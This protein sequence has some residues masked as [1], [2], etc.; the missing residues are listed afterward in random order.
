MPEVSRVLPGVT[1]IDDGGGVPVRVV[2]V[3][4]AEKGAYG[5]CGEA[6]LVIVSPSE[7]KVVPVDQSGSL[8][9]G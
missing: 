6:V 7:G 1:G 2:L 4:E 5:E 3:G 8:S 9:K